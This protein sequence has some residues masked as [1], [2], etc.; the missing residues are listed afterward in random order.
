MHNNK[1]NITRI[2]AVHNALGDLKDQ[3]VFVGGATVALYSD[4]ATYEVRPTDDVDI[5]VEIYTRKQY[6]ELEEQLRLKGF[7]NDVS[8]K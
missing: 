2:K 4:R 5:L 3:I 6:A 7:Q 1:Y 8:A